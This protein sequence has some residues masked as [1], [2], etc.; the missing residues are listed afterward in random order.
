MNLIIALIYLLLTFS[1]T[2]LCYKFFGKYGLFVW[3]CVSIIICN[4]QTVKMA[5]ILNF[6][7]SLGNIAYASIFFATDII[8]EKYGF[9]ENR[10][11]NNFSLIIMIVFTI[12]MTLFLQFKPSSVD[13]SQNALIQIFSV[14]PR[15]TIA[16][17]TAYYLSQLT[18]A[19]LYRY[20]KQK[21]NK[22]WIS[23][24]GS[25]IISQI[26]D[27]IIFVIIAFAGTMPIAIIG[28]I[29]ITMILFK[30]V[31]AFLDTPFMYLINSF[32]NIKEL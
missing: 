9:E 16:S 31:I 2:A 14:M 23:N 17:L 6:T 32:N 10:K 18:D 22:L 24:N 25:T 21:Y 26:I 8:N 19:H 29:I 4:I 5:E 7:T 27:S 1:L 20:L 30:I 15:I 13:E 28:E 3:I 12:F 11:I